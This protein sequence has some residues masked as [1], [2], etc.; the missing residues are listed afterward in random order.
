MQFPQVHNF[1]HVWMKKNPRHEKTPM[2]PNRELADQLRL[3]SNYY[4]DQKQQY[5][6]NAYYNAAMAIRSYP[7]LITSGQQ[8]R[9]EIKG[10]GQSISLDIDQYLSTG[11]ISRLEELKNLYQEKQH[12]IIDLFKSVHGIGPVTAK[13]YYDLGYRTLDDLW[14]RGNLTNAQKLGIIYYEH[15]Q[16]KIPRD[17]M[18]IINSVFEQ[19]FNQYDPDLEWVI[20]GSYR[21]GEPDSGDIDLLIK[22]KDGVGLSDIISLLKEIEIEGSDQKG[23]LVGDLALGQQKYLGIFRLSPEYNAHRIDILFVPEEEWAYAVLYFTGSRKFNILM[24]KVA[25]DFGLTLN[26][27]GLMDADGNQY[28][29]KTEEDIF[30]MLNLVYLRPE[31][32]TRNIETLDILYRAD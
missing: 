1:C 18:D 6:S 2:E 9:Q 21:R 29:A 11:K 32:R 16:Q 14:N 4:R 23:V 30:T 19:T 8:A 12:E 5:R 3:V 26:E 31:D 17:E 7:K 22:M 15:L 13:R 10:I 20:T 27:H 24:R 25:S 28:P